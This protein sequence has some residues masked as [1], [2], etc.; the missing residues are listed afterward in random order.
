MADNATPLVDDVLP[1]QP[2]RQWVLGN[3]SLHC[4]TSHIHVV[5]SVPGSHD[6]GKT[7][8]TCIWY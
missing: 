3:C 2:M 5:V 8:K 4:S 6:L 7:V 1:H